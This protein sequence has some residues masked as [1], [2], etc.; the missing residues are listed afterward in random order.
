MARRWSPAE[1]L[2]RHQ[3]RRRLALS[4]IRPAS[5]WVACW[6]SASAT[7]RSIGSSPAGSWPPAGRWIGPSRE[8]APHRW[9][10]ASGYGSS[11]TAANWSASICWPG[12]RRSAAADQVEPGTSARQPEVL[13]RLDMIG[14]LGVVPHNMSSCSVTAAGDLLLVMTGNG[15]NES[16]T[17]VPAPQAP[18]FFAV[19]RRRARW[20]GPTVRRAA[21]S[22]TANGRRRR[23]LLS[24][25]CR[26]PSFPAATAGC[27]A[28]R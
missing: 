4:S 8:S 14:Q 23:S 13:W 15:V 19:Y 9:S 25:A 24:A 1:G 21:I 11:P 10:R 27:I 5:I 26:R 12:R 20:F 16:H 22:S 3:Q 28:S 6:P 2:P 17:R 7:A 18:S